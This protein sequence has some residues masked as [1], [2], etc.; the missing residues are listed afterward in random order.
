VTGRTAAKA[1]LG[2]SGLVVGL[3]GITLELRVA[4]WAAVALLAATV[5][6]RFAGP[7]APS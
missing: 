5:V 2:G 7:R 6:L 3:V 1:W 4:V